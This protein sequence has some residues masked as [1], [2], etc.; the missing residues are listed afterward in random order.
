MALRRMGIESTAHEFRS[1]FR[2]ASERTNFPREV[3]EQ[4]LAHTI[5]DKTEA[6]YRRGG[7]LMAAWAEFATSN[8]ADITAVA[9]DDSRPEFGE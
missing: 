7:E 8:S 2:W 9:A 4:A 5:K 3:C 6:A 1:A